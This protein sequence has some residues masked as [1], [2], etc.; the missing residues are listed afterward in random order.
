VDEKCYRALY[1]I[2]LG[3]KT[4]VKEWTLKSLFILS[5]IIL[6]F[7]LLD[8]WLLD[9]TWVAFGGA[10]VNNKK[11]GSPSKLDGKFECAEFGG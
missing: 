4:R 5:S 11:I 3:L 7:L 6:S 8:E 2:L 10:M 1:N 9:Y